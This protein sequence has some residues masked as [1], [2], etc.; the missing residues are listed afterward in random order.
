MSNKITKKDP[1]HK[2]FKFFAL[3]TKGNEKFPFGHF[4]PDFK[5]PLVI[6]KVGSLTLSRFISINLC[7]IYYAS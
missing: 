5:I 2:Y 3:S 6:Q 7:T 1:P 4:Q